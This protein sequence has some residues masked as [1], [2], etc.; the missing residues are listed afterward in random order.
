[1]VTTQEPLGADKVL[2]TVAVL[3][4]AKLVAAMLSRAAGR[5]GSCIFDAATCLTG[6][7]RIR[8]QMWV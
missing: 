4:E 7:L 8:G 5:A 2:A 6:R 1:M 3:D